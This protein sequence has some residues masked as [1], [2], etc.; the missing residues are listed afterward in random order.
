MTDHKHYPT[1]DVM[2][3]S[4]EWDA[5]TRSI[6]NARL[7]REYSY[8]FLTTVEAET[9]RS[10]CSLLMDDD[11][12]EI[13]QSIISHIDRI[14]FENKGEGHRKAGTPSM[15]VLLR[16]GLKAIDETGWFTNSQPFFQLDEMNQRNIMLHIGEASYPAT[17]NWEGIPQKAL[18]HKLMQLSVEA[19]YAHPLVWSEIGFGG[20]AYPRGYSLDSPEQLETWEA[21]KPS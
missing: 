18:F 1:Y 7:V 21:V 19:Y 2:K 14:L 15:R 8:N 11:R 6:V 17:K 5:H 20:P 3:E 12:G 13:I 10:W 4:T 9:L 16:Q